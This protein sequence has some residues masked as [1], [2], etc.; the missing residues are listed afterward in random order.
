MILCKKY[1]KLTCICN[2]ILKL[3]TQDKNSI[4]MA[5]TEQQKIF[6]ARFFRLPP[7]TQPFYCSAG[8]CPGL[9]GWA[10]TRKVKPGR[11]KPI[12]Q[13]GFTGARDSEWQWHLLGYMQCLLPST[14]C[15]VSPRG[16]HMG[17][18]PLV[19]TRRV[20]PCMAQSRLGAFP[21]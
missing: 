20:P 12:C 21:R 13:S 1:L 7:H 6:D 11:L 2:K 19:H 8:I 18:P 17:S 5:N 15:K 14:S 9:P 16:R 3:Q 4:Y 10:G